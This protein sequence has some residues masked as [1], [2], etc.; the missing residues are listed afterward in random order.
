MSV[1]SNGGHIGIRE[2]GTILS[3][4]SSNTRED[5]DARD[6]T[7]RKLPGDGVTYDEVSL[8][9]SVATSQSPLSL[10]SILTMFRNCTA[11]DPRDKVFAFLNIAEKADPKFASSG[12]KPDYRLCTKDVYLKTTQYLLRASGLAVLTLIQDKKLTSLEDLPSWVPDFSVELGRSMHNIPR[13]GEPLPV[14]HT[15]KVP[16][17]VTEGRFLTLKGLKLNVVSEVTS[18]NGCYFN[19]VAELALKTPDWYLDN[20]T[21]QP[22]FAQYRPQ[23]QAKDRRPLLVPIRVDSSSTH[24]SRVEALWRTLTLDFFDGKSPA[25]ARCGFGFSDWVAVHVARA[26][27]TLKVLKLQK[28]QLQS[29]ENRVPVDDYTWQKFTSTYDSWS[30]LD[31]GEAGG[32]YSPEEL[33]NAKDAILD[34]KSDDY[35]VWSAITKGRGLDIEAGGIRYLPAFRRLRTFLS[36]APSTVGGLVV[37]ARNETGLVDT[38][39]ARLAAFEKRIKEVK[40]GRRLF[41]TPNHFLGMGPTSTAVGDEVW[42]F[43]GGSSPFLLRPTSD[44]MYELVGEA[45]VHGIFDVEPL[46]RGANDFCKVTL[47]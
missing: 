42:V 25:P 43:E 38:E 23:N 34:S 37:V 39:K 16:F 41:R 45:Y 24:I 28:S 46:N 4:D 30:A 31:D 15:T 20:R 13:S 3:D 40:V 19:R 29:S 6:L 32:F 26:W 8:P 44:G 7:V 33:E 18:L 12:F 36:Q 10:L 21:V 5:V 9:T 1:P 47:K 27:N 22:P 2:P 35:A 14:E 11:T 17:E